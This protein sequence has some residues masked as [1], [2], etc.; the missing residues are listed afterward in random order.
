MKPYYHFLNWKVHSVGL[1]LPNSM[2]D[3]GSTLKCCL[4]L[5]TSVI[6]IQV[7]SIHHYNV[8]QHWRDFH[9]LLTTFFF[10]TFISLFFMQEFYF[11][12]WVILHCVVATFSL[13]KVNTSSTGDIIKPQLPSSVPI[14][15]FTYSPLNYL[16]SALYHFS[17]SI[18]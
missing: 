6:I 5:N 14:Y 1:N 11:T 2:S 4:H 12:N 18:L 16:L 3:T 13:V 10:F 8:Y 17:Y 9:T 15:I 7:P